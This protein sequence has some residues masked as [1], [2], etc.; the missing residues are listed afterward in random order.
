M[1]IEFR[2]T[3]CNKLLRTADN[4]AGKHARCPECGEI[5]TIP[6]GGATI[7]P[8]TPLP[9]T[10][11]SSTPP[12]PSPFAPTTHAAGGGGFSPPPGGPTGGSPFG[13]GQQPDYRPDTGNPYQS[14][15][16]YAALPRQ[17]V[18]TSGEIR[19]TQIDF[20]NIYSSAWAVFAKQWLGAVL[21]IFI[22]AIVFFVCWIGMAMVAGMIGM[23]SRNISV[24]FVCI[25]IG[26]L[27]L[28][29]FGIYLLAGAIRYF[30]NL[31]RGEY[32]PLG[33]LFSGGPYF[34]SLFL[35]ILLTFL[36][37][38][39][40]YIVCIVPGF[41]VGVASPKMG[42]GVSIIGVILY[43]ILG[44]Y[45]WLTLF[46]SQFFV[47][48]QNVGA[49]DSIRLSA[50]YMRGNKLILFLIMLV[51]FIAFSGPIFVMFFVMFSSLRMVGRPAIA[52]VV[53]FYIFAFV[54]EWLGMSFFATLA[55]VIYLK[56]TGQPTLADRSI[57][58]GMR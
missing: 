36:I 32:L 52:P 57:G 4:T 21:G 14:P 26:Y 43:S 34:V 39:G 29:V 11:P 12:A 44:I 40:I 9:P 51:F 2:C 55:S 58:M 47:V 6:A 27:L 35:L 46:P 53:G 54:W 56:V 20:G 37:N 49:I 38:L 3:K 23:I 45:V 5:L 22:L 30:L 42:L 25:F 19:P 31:A 10:P 16:A 15:S 28:F 1:P 13:T 18:G 50:T 8:P 7:S 33:D 17:G 48:D 24:L 41:A